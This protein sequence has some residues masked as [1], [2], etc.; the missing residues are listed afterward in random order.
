MTGS[1][2]PLQTQFAENVVE[3]SEFSHVF[4]VHFCGHGLQGEC[5]GW[6][7][8][9]RLGQTREARP[10]VH[11]N[12]DF[13]DELSRYRCHDGRTQNLLFALGGINHLNHAFGGVVA[14][15][16]IH[17][18]E[19]LGRDGNC[20]FSEF[21]LGGSLGISNRGYL[22]ARKGGGRNLVAQFSRIGE[23]EKNISSRNRS[24]VACDNDIFG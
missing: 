17:L 19:V 8:V 21:G 20:I 15:S 11:G 12:A 7:G 22:G 18:A 5:V 1:S 23:G 3:P 2:I 24:L 9:N 10:R 6:V 4:V 14:D 13:A 16:P